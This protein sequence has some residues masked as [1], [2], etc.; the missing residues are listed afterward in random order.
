MDIRTDAQIPPV[1]YRTS[2]PFG[3]AA[4][5]VH[6]FLN[7]LEKFNEWPWSHYPNSKHFDMAK[8]R[9]QQSGLA[10]MY[11]LLFPPLILTLTRLVAAV[12]SLKDRQL[13]S[14]SWPFSYYSGSH[15]Q[16][17]IAPIKW[18]CFNPHRFFYEMRQKSWGCQGFFCS[19]V[20]NWIEIFIAL[21]QQ[22]NK[23]CKQSFSWPFVFES[24]NKRLNTI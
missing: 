13:W 24:S 23:P 19:S 16:L 11:F 14:I 17:Y 6:D 3:A 2:S 20:Q 7:Q 1:F 5:K 21:I 18:V 4:Q 12:H 15:G 9:W 22:E 10:N 8:K